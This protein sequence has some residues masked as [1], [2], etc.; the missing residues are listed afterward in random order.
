MLFLPSLCR[1]ILRYSL[2]G[3]MNTWRVSTL[4][5]GSWRLCERWMRIIFYGYI[6]FFRVEISHLL[7][8]DGRIIH[9]KSNS[10]LEVR[11]FED[12]ANVKIISF[13]FN[14]ITFLYKRLN[15]QRF[16]SVF[17]IFSPVFLPFSL[18]FHSLSPRGEKPDR[19]RY[20][21]LR[22]IVRAAVTFV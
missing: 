9:D 14:A 1:F 12:H 21:Q 5:L 16:S 20:T 17:R 15:F 3:W 6:L 18:R 13:G 22:K 2:I 10:R 11:N 7:V 4:R 8:N 19:S